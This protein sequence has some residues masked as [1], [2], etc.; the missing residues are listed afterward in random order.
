MVRRLFG[1]QGEEGEE[2]AREEGGAGAPV[3]IERFMQR[4]GKV[5]IYIYIYVCVLCLCLC[6]VVLCCVGDVLCCVV[7]C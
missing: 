1:A 2:G 4:T 5:S 6:C 3:N 7:L